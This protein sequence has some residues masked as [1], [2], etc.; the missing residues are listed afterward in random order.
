MNGPMGSQITSSWSVLAINLR[1]AQTPDQKIDSLFLSLY[2]RYPSPKERDVLH[3][4]LESY[5][6]NKSLWEDL[7]VAALST[8]QFIFIK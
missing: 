7:I 6:S 5:A 3:Q 8:Q 1:K 4:R 2:S